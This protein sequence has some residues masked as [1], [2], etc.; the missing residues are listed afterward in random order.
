MHAR[1]L[2]WFIVFV[3]VTGFLS[4]AVAQVITEPYSISTFAGVPTR[5]GSTDGPGAPPYLN[6]PSGIAA[7]AV[8]NLYLADTS[9]HIIRRITP[10]GTVSTLAGLIGVIGSIDGNAADARFR[11]PSGLAIDAA[12]NLYVADA[13]NHVIRKISSNGT[14]RTLAGLAGSSGSRDGMGSNARFNTPYSVAVDRAG[15][16]YV[17]DQENHTIRKISSDD[18]VTTFAGLA[19]TEGSADGYASAA[20]FRYPAGLAFDPAGDLYVADKGNTTIRKVDSARMVETLAGAAGMFGNTDGDAKNA[21]FTFPSGVAVDRDFNVYVTDCHNHTIRKVTSTGIVSTLAG[22]S[23]TSGN[24]EGSGGAARFHYPSGI[25]LDDAGK[26]YVADEWNHS[27]REIDNTTSVTTKVGPQGFFDQP[28]GVA[29]DSAGNIYVADQ[30]NH[31]IRKI[32]SE[33]L[34]NTFAGLAGVSGNTDGVGNAARFYYPSGVAVDSADNVFVADRYNGVIRKITSD[35]LVSTVAAS[36]ANRGDPHSVAVDSVGNLYVTDLNGSTVRKFTPDGGVTTLA[37]MRSSFGCNDGTGSAARFNHPNGIAVD[38]AGN[39]YV[40][41]QY[42]HTVRKVAPDGAVTTFAGK[43]NVRGGNDGV[44][45]AAEFS[46]P[47]GL[48]ADSIDNI[49]VVEDG[50]TIRKITPSGVVTTLAGTTNH[51]GFLDGRGRVARFYRPSGIALSH[52][53]DF[54]VADTNNDVIRLAKP[55]TPVEIV[56]IRADSSGIRLRG[57]GVSDA[58]NRIESSLDLSSGSFNTLA[59]IEVDGSGAFTYVDRDSNRKRFYRLAYP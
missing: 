15:C 19:G 38:S 4:I 8:G 59:T 12:G 5:S 7:D 52:L 47:N 36:A 43:P 21:R 20:R 34:V 51:S 25:A 31:T 33:G 13:G 42:C 35:G 29:L 53:G 46:S 58:V 16:V 54:Y 11:F 10:D 32:T 27:I 6:F 9:N 23:R 17:A 48:V 55:T 30:V 40:A 49:Y 18:L 57:L 50:G 39:V 28:S 56:S 2:F 41:D 37:G 3:G 24:V 26:V 44:G 22:L 1:S 45:N 14:V